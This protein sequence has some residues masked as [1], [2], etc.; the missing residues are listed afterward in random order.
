MY[1]EECNTNLKTGTNTPSELLDVNG[2]IRA[3]RFNVG[4]WTL[5]GNHSIYYRSSTGAGTPNGISFKWSSPYI[6]GR[7]DNGG[8]VNLGWTLIISTTDANIRKVT[9]IRNSQYLTYNWYAYPGISPPYAGGNG[10][11]MVFSQSGL[12]SGFSHLDYHVK[13]TQIWDIN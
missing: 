5:V 10:L 4:A 12:P 3:T 6:Y 1:C 13:I 11:I 9:E 8:N 2:N 7:V